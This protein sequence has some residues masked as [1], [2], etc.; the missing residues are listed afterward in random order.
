MTSAYILVAAMLILGGFIA[1]LGDRIGSK[2]GK[3]R[4]K[5]FNLRPRQTAQ[6]VTILTGT[7]IAASTLVIL[8]TLSKSLRQGVFE[9]DEILR[10]L[11]TVKADLDQASSEKNQAKQALSEAKTEQTKAQTS[12]NQVKLNFSRARNQLKAASSQANQLRSDIQ[13]LVTDRQQLLGQK[14]QL[15]QQ[16]SQLQ[17]QVQVQNEQVQV[18]DGEL[19]KQESKI[20][21]QDQTLKQRQLRLQAVE[22]QFQV[23]E[24]QQKQL[25]LEINQ[26]DQ[27]IGQL[28]T[29]I[30]QKDQNLKQ[31]E[32]KLKELES[33]L[34][35]L[36]RE[37]AVLEQYYQNYQDLRER[38]IALVRGQV[39]AFG[40]VR[41]VD[42]KASIK[43]VD[44]LL[45]Q[46]NRT[47]IQATRSGNPDSDEQVVKITKAQVEELIQQLQDQRDYV[48]RIISAG[49]YVQGEKEIRVFADVALNQ[50]IFKENE[51]L[52]TVSLDADNLREEDIQ[53]R[54]DLLLS[55]AQFKARSSGI[56]GTLQV[57]DGRIKTLIDFAE[58]VSKSEESLDEIRAVAAADTYTAGPLKI[59]LVAIKDG[60]VIFRT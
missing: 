17:V 8:F 7:L 45:R 19:K 55:A 5:L 36:Q 44:E 32:N 53:K 20:A 4:L 28:D 39:L 23:L 21:A 30:A 12:L 58:E 18:K 51:T 15:A 49:N 48:V 34:E 29:A 3:A 33:Q 24:K 57:G 50:K 22:K 9:L 54:L 27:M 40:A 6:L 41:V 1:V 59:R 11:R 14:A 60:V 31:R 52:A 43:V 2:I 37:V 42:P 25:Q 47:A 26:R 13:K 35:F 46:A 16:F 10:Q 56:L 38:N